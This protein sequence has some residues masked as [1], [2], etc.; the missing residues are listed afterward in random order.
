[1]IKRLKREP[2][3]IVEIPAELVEHWLKAKEMAKGAKAVK[4]AAQIE[5]LNALGDA[6]AGQWGTGELLTFL[7]QTKKGIDLTRLRVERPE[8]A[9]EYLKPSTFRVPRIKKPKKSKF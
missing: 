4:D 2:D 5:M 8:I 3:K 1:M 6:E 7:E 9:A